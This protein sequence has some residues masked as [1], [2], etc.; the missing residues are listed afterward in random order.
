M[1]Y[2]S[3]KATYD[4]DSPVPDFVET[5]FNDNVRILKIMQLKYSIQNGNIPSS[6]WR[7]RV[8]K[9]FADDMSLKLLSLSECLKTET[10]KQANI[11]QKNSHS[12]I[13]KNFKETLLQSGF[14]LVKPYADVL[15][16]VLREKKAQMKRNSE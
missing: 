7:K 1:K 4:I 5:I 16:K 8:D 15:G 10:R 13:S 2:K 6:E 11:F 14:D 9:E 12:T 3:L